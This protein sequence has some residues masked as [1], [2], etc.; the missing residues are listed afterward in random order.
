[1]ENSLWILHSHWSVHAAVVD[2]GRVH[3][4]V[5]PKEEIFLDV[6]GVLAVRVPWVWPVH[7]VVWFSRGVGL[8]SRC[9]G[10]SWRPYQLRGATAFPI[11]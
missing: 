6:G 4:A 8:F 10:E 7:V 1:M 3:S 5:R 2:V 11:T 9:R